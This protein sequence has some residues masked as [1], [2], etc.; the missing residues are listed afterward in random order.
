MADIKTSSAL[1]RFLERVAKESVEE[2]LPPV[3]ESERKEQARLGKDLEGLHASD[4]NKKDEVEEEEG[5]GKDTDGE[6]KK[7]VKKKDITKLGSADKEPKSVDIPTSKE[8]LGAGLRDVI[9]QLN[10]IRSGTS[11]K[12]E[13]VRKNLDAYIA[14]LSSSER[15]SLF[16]FLSGISQIVSAG[17]SGADSPSPGEVGITMKSR[18]EKPSAKKASSPAE[19][20]KSNDVEDEAPPIVVGESADKGDILRK[21]RRLMRSV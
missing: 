3:Y 21:A 5:T 11:L 20:A 12:D 19:K 18:T 7:V 13:K 1:L 14:A 9:D 16:V 15:Q 4:K 8:V 6:K 10:M 17:V 2:V